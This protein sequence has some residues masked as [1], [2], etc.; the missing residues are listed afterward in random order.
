MFFTPVIHI[1][2]AILHSVF[3]LSPHIFRVQN[4][5]EREKEREREVSD[6]K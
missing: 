1:W 4:E 3:P 5:R 2:N 6:F